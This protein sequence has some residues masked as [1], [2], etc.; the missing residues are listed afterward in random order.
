MSRVLSPDGRASS[1]DDLHAEIGL[2]WL[3]CRQ[4]Q[5]LFVVPGGWSLVLH[6]SCKLTD[7]KMP[8]SLECKRKSACRLLRVPDDALERWIDASQV[9]SNPAM[10]N[11][12]SDWQN[13]RTSSLSKG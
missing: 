2:P 7:G 13:S 11:S 3:A 6:V 5:R 10:Q 9:P 4:G 1:R 8:A 12:S